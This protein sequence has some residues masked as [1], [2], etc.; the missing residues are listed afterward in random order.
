[1][2]KIPL[3][4]VESAQHVFAGPKNPIRCS[5]LAS[6]GR[7]SMRVYMISI[8][9]C[10][11][12][13]G[14]ESA[15]TGSV[16]HAGVAAFHLAEGGL[17]VREKAAWDAIAKARTTFPLA[18]ETEVRL[19]ITPYMN[20]MRNITAKFATWIDPSDKQEKPCIEMPVEFTLPPHPFDKT[21]QT[22]YVNGHLDYIRL[23]NG[24]HYVDDLKTGKVSGW[25]MLHDYAVQL[26][27]YTYGARQLGVTKAIPGRII[28][29]M[30]Y[31]TRADKG[32]SPDGVFWS[33]PFT[34]NDVETLLENVR[35]HVALVRNGDVQ[36][37]PGPHCTYCE[38]GGLQ[39]C[40]NKWKEINNG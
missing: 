29:A 26:A 31:R 32:A 28:R 11:D 37:Q 17:K 27:A 35:L 1:M 21:K 20:D 5:K 6:I 10:E 30:G 19:F 2:K 7:C 9:D 8:L 38:F 13:E 25:Q 12:G 18:D 15:Q 23:V 36:F 34:W 16:V 39:G 4:Q 14:G 3:K 40:L 33:L 22:I 24:F